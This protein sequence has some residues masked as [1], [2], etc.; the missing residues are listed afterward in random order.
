MP[1]ARS[2]ASGPTN[3][4]SLGKASMVGVNEIR[5]MGWSGVLQASDE[6]KLGQ[7]FTHTRRHGRK[8]IAR[9]T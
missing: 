8:S 7:S 4:T 2:I 1:V 9:R 6:A 5:G 3:G